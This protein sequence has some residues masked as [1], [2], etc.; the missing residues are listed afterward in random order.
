MPFTLPGDSQKLR[1]ETPILY[2]INTLGGM[3]GAGCAGLF[4]PL[5]LGVRG[6]FIAAICINLILTVVCVTMS[7]FIKS[8]YEESTEDVIYS[9]AGQT[10]RSKRLLPR[11]L[12]TFAAFSGIGTLALEVLWTRM[13]SLVLQNSV[14][15]LALL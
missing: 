15:G 9:H 13:F 6:S 11:H 2:G 10:L 4:F 8:K 5:W 1:R 7:F 14:Y 3:I 12:F